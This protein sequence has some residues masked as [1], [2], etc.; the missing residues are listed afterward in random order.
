MGAQSQG[1]PE[2]QAVS[3]AVN[4]LDQYPDASAD[5][6]EKKTDTL[7]SENAKADSKGTSLKVRRETATERNPT[8]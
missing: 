2:V 5:T 4:P 3:A 8:G 6:A 7:K 1:K